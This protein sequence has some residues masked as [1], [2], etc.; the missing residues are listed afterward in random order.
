MV[1]DASLGKV[2][3]IVL[4]AWNGN[5]LDVSVGCVYIH[6]FVYDEKSRNN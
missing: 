6:V 2:L 5:M 4:D 3:G 1:L